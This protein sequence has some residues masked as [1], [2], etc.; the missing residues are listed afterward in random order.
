MATILPSLLGLCVAAVSSSVGMQV[1]KFGTAKV[2]ETQKAELPSS[3]LDRVGLAVT[4]TV[5]ACAFAAHKYPLQSIGAA[6]V[7][8]SVWLYRRVTNPIKRLW[9]PAARLLH[10]LGD[11]VGGAGWVALVVMSALGVR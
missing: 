5:F 7:L 4:V 2:T 9:P 11:V 3:G 10:C 1:A 8:E 6:A